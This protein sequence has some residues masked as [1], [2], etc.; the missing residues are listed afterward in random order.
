[1][2]AIAYLPSAAVRLCCE[3]KPD[4]DALM[5][6]VIPPNVYATFLEFPHRPEGDGGSVQSLDPTGATASAAADG[7]IF[8]YIR[9]LVGQ[10]EWIRRAW[11]GIKKLPVM[12]GFV[13][14]PA[15]TGE[16][17]RQR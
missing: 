3:F 15:F 14:L 13:G 10:H 9:Y 8:L 2:K 7:L 1:M 6:D 5:R 4:I 12:S 11:C 17:H 16:S